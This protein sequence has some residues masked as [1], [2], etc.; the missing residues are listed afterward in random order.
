MP[1]GPE[2]DDQV[3]LAIIRV[4]QGLPGF[5]F[6]APLKAWIYRVAINSAR[7]SHQLNKFKDLSAKKKFLA[8]VGVGTGAFGMYGTGKT[9]Y[10]SVR[11][12]SSDKREDQD[13]SSSSKSICSQIR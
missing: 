13:S 11:P 7:K 12:S 4:F 10:D 6:E 1:R 2:V 3:Q 8:I 9:I 5:N